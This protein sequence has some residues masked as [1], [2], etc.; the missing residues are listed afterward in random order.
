MSGSSSMFL[1][2]CCS[3]SQNIQ[4]LLHFDGNKSLDRRR[5]NKHKN[6]NCAS[7]L[8]RVCIYIFFFLSVVLAQLSNLPARTPLVKLL[9]YWSRTCTQ[10]GRQAGGRTGTH[11]HRHTKKMCLRSHTHTHTQAQ[12]SGVISRCVYTLVSIRYR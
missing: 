9:E 5:Q 10:A 11:T 6:T 1:F 3:T 7:T 2:S 8:L 12:F 4:R